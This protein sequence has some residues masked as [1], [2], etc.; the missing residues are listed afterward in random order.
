LHFSA[1]DLGGPYGIDI[2]VIVNV[3]LGDI[4]IK[5][6]NVDWKDL[7]SDGWMTPEPI[8]KYHDNNGNVHSEPN[9]EYAVYSKYPNSSPY[10]AGVLDSIE[11]VD[12]TLDWSY[13]HWWYKYS[14]SSIGATCQNVAHHPYNLQVDMSTSSTDVMIRF[15]VQYG[16][17]SPI[18]L[19]VGQDSNSLSQSQN[20]VPDQWWIINN[21]EKVYNNFV[22]NYNSDGRSRYDTYIVSLVTYNIEISTDNGKTW[23]PIK[24]GQDDVWFEYDGNLTS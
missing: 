22:Y 16:D 11:Y 3:G 21:L 7:G 9:Y 14:G 17:S 12:S 18:T 6:N 10:I 13:S 24:E 23:V 2:P 19:T 4:S 1:S 15:I 5:V 20:I 8:G